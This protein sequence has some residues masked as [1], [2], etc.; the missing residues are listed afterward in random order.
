MITRVQALEL[1]H[2]NIIID[3]YG[4]SWRVKGKI[5]TWKTR[6]EDF[7]IPI[8]HGLYTYGYLTKHN[9]DLF[10]LLEDI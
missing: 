2:G 9:N 7:K 4:K 8:K 6:P 1:K 5:Q 3:I 10:S